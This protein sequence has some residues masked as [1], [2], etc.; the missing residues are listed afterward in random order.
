M[1]QL[2]FK[3]FGCRTNSEETNAYATEFLSHGY[4]RV[5]TPEEADIIVIN[6]CSVTNQTEQK[7][8]RYIASIHEKYPF[9]EIALTGCLA[10]QW[11]DLPRVHGITWLIDNTRK[12]DIVSVVTSETGGTFTGTLSEKSAVSQ[13]FQIPHPENAQRT[14]LSLKIQEGCNKACSYCIVPRLRGPARSISAA[15]VLRTA[16]H[17]LR[18]GY[19]E[20]ILTGTHIG[21]YR[22]GT[23]KYLDILHN[24]LSLDTSL[25]IRLSSMNPED[26]T[27]DLIALF[28]EHNNLC[29]HL[30]I[31]F[32][33]LSSDV[34][35][36]MNRS[37]RAV[38]TLQPTLAKL[39]TQFPDFS[40]GG[41]FIVGHPGESSDAFSHTCARLEEYGISYGHVFRYS[42]RP[43][44]AAAEMNDAPPS[45]ISTER[46]RHIR[47]ILESLRTQFLEKQQGKTEF[48]ISEKKVYYKVLPVI[49]FLL[50][51]PPTRM[52]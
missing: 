41:D 36:R 52:W 12:K 11:Q 43:Q 35:K 14:R 38:E 2:Y 39:C 10:Q 33:S 4:S 51:C 23:A 49:I 5:A 37:V 27:P 50:R 1:K 6:G 32:Q 20:I 18:L 19:R 9:I 45:H 26:I 25:R 22:D 40:I 42:P 28:T 17:A 24:L 7:I 3:T 31:S 46:S 15:E 13:F 29:H 44:T 8:R 30:H 48:I 16:K 21:Q 47:K 34:L